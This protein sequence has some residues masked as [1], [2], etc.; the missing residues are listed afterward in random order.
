MERSTMM[1]KEML[2]FVLILAIPILSFSQF[3][4]DKC[5]YDLDQRA[6]MPQ[7]PSGT[8]ESKYGY[9]LPVTGTIR[10]LI[11]FA[12]IEYDTGTDPNPNNQEEWKVGELPTWVDELFDPNI[13]IGQA[14]GIVTR[15]FQEASFGSYNVLGDYLVKSS[16]SNEIFTVLNSECQTKGYNEALCSIISQVTNGNFYTGHGLNNVT[17]FDNWT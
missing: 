10:L 15:Y 6:F 2:V 4:E 12:Q 7:I 9:R 13:P 5:L 11:V 3:S 17:Y 8:Y 1:V 14:N 16:G